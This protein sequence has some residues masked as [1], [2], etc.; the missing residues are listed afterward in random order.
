MLFKQFNER[1][2]SHL[3]RKRR[4]PLEFIIGFKKDSLTLPWKNGEL[5]HRLLWADNADAISRLYAGT[6]ALK[7]DFT[8]TGMRT[9]RG[10]LDDG[11]NSVTRFYRNNFL[12][13]DRQKGMDLLTGFSKFQIN[14]E[15]EDHSYRSK[16]SVKTMKASQR[17]PFIPHHKLNLGWLPGDLE[18][19]LRS[20]ALTAQTS[21]MAVEKSIRSDSFSSAEALSDIGRRGSLEKPWW[22][23][24][25]EKSIV[26][27]NKSSPLLST[28]ALTNSGYVLGALL[29][30]NHAPIATVIAIICLLSPGITMDHQ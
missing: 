23:D 21:N 27:A 10:A 1:Y 22:I 19:H 6:P 30:L 14:Y 26:D 25:N 3:S 15:D 2:N 12:D 11:L 17:A 9:K 28:V 20:A 4:L 29:A 13:G 8:R 24:V 7:G 16:F 18:S 5:S